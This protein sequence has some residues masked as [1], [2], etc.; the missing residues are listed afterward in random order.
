MLHCDRIG[1][2]LLSKIAASDIAAFAPGGCYSA[3]PRL[4]IGQR[5]LDRELLAVFINENQKESRSR[6]RARFGGRPI[7]GCPA[8]PTS[9]RRAARASPSCQI[10]GRGR[11][12]RALAAVSGPRVP[13][14]ADTCRN[15]PHTDAQ[16]SMS[17][18][19]TSLRSDASPL[20]SFLALMFSGRPHG[21]SPGRLRTAGASR[22]GRS[23]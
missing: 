10:I 9:A 11:C 4:V 17:R 13:P 5:S 22:I 20:G 2:G 16:A 19:T 14:A 23:A 15:M 3:I 21:E 6:H 7:I 18:N 12:C 8:P 1:P